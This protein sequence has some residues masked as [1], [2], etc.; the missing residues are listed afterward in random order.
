V[1]LW[2]DHDEKKSFFVFLNYFDVHDPYLPPQPYRSRFSN[3]ENAGGILNGQ[4][5]PVVLTTE[6]LQG[7]IDA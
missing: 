4:Q 5:P 2:L 7:E 6:Q 1:L 3:L